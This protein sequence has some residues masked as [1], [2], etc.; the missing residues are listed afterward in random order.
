MIPPE[1]DW[2]CSLPEEV[3]EATSLSLRHQLMSVGVQEPDLGHA[4]N[5]LH[6]SMLTCDLYL[7]YL[8]GRLG[9]VSTLR[10]VTMWAIHSGRVQPARFQA[11]RKTSEVVRN[12]ILAAAGAELQDADMHT[13]LTLYT[14][15]LKKEEQTDEDLADSQVGERG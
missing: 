3:L 2:L 9:L 12:V 5:E 7:R 15:A 14:W 4:I 8:R 10:R 11:L 1:F 6:E 13:A